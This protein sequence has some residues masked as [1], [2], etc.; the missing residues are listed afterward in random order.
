MKLRL[1]S[2]FV[3][4]LLCGCGPATS[5]GEANS[6]RVETAQPDELSSATSALAVPLTTVES[7]SSG[8]RSEIDIVA[9]ASLAR[10]TKD[11]SF[12]GADVFDRVNVVDRYGTPTQDGFLEFGP[13][14]ALI[15]P[16][17]RAAVEQALTPIS[18][19]WVDGLSDVVGTGQKLPTEED[20]WLTLSSPIVAGDRAEI[21]TGLW[22]GSLCGVGGAYGLEWTESTGW[23]ITGMEG[24]QWIS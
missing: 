22:C 7:G 16:E 5:T 4:G 15:G 8:E 19:T 1:T 11:N 3:A 6:S 13:D 9:T 20:V 21:T 2:L 24:P 10:L 23:F 12:G 17:V 18:V 14:S